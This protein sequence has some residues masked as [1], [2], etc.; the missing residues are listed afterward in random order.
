MLRGAASP[1]WI[2]IRPAAGGPDLR[3]PY[4][5]SLGPGQTADIVVLDVP[6][7]GE[8]GVTDWILF[9]PVDAHG[10]PT[11]HIYPYA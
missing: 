9:R 11:P 3:I 10:V 4:W 2:R 1:V 6:P 8:T 5:M 7:K